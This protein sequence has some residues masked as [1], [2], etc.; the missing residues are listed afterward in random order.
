[1][2]APANFRRRSGAPARAAWL[3]LPQRRQL[4]LLVRRQDLIDLRHRRASDGRQLAHLA[5]FGARELLDLRR[6]IGLTAAR[7]DCRV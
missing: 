2:I 4:L 1:M 7:N 3:R 5:A 6:I